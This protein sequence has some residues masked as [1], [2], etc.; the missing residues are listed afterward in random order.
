MV[1]RSWDKTHGINTKCI[2]CLTNDKYAYSIPHPHATLVPKVKV[3]STQDK[4]SIS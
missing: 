4:H 3:S 2:R 1:Q